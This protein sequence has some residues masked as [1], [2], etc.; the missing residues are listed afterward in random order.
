MNNVILK[1]IKNWCNE[2]FQ[3]KENFLERLSNNLFTTE[4]GFALDARQGTALQ[5]EI[6]EINSNLGIFQV[7][8]ILR[9]AYSNIS[10]DNGTKVYSIDLNQDAEFLR[11]VNAGKIPY[12]INA[13][14][15]TENTSFVIN[16]I[17]DFGQNSGTVRVSVTNNGGN[18]KVTIR[19]LIV[20]RD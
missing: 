19:L 6:N 2:K 3:S 10:V 20:W 1:A 11:L 14:V 12:V 15:Y 18:A 5:G 13:C 17:I 16:N 8:G 9:H 7:H 4:E